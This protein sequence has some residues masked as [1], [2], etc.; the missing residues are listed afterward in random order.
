MTA[1][2]NHELQNGEMNSVKVLETAC[3]DEPMPRQK[4]GFVTGLAAEARLLRKSGFLVRVGGGMPE[5]AERAAEELAAAG[6][7]VLISFGLAGGLNVERKPGDVLVPCAVIE[8]PQAYPCDYALMEWLGGSTG[9]PILAARRIAESAHQKSVLYNSSRAD[10]VDLESGAVA[11]VARARNLRF[12]V[13]RA[14]ADPARRDLPPAALTALKPN[15]RIDLPRILLSVLTRPW[16]VAGL[17]AV[18]RDAAAART[19]LIRRLATIRI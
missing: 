1:A 8:G 5:G 12:A 14:I 9:R 19:A 2:D 3:Y 13:L 16:Q 6:A 15:G 17:L 4:I 11:R 7:D 10:G 18:G